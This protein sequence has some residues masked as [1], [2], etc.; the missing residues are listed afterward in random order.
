MMGEGVY[1]Y[2]AGWWAEAGEYPKLPWEDALVLRR[3]SHGGSGEQAKLLVE[4]VEGFR[5]IA[6]NLAQLLLGEIGPLL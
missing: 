4:A 3:P 5:V 2:V 6:E 1:S